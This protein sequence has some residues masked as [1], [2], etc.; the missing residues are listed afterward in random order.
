MEAPKF[1]GI[2]GDVVAY[3]VAFKSQKEGDR[4]EDALAATRAFLQSIIN[5]CGE[6]GVIYLTG[7]K[8]YRF[9][10]AGLAYPYKGNRK[11]QEKPVFL[12]DIRN[13]MID[14]F[15]AEVQEEQ[16]A[17][18]ALAIGAVQRR[19]GIATVD[20]DLDGVAGWHYNWRKQTKY[21]VTEVEADRFF[22]TQMLTGDAVDNIPGLSKRT[23]KKAMPKIK[24]PLQEM[25]DPSEMYTYVYQVYMDAVEEKAMSSDASD[26]TRW[27]LQQGR[28]L[29]MRREEDQIWVAP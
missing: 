9:A 1:W 22:Y 13:Y 3:A 8:N 11:D 7:S 28:C 26:V 27:L 6:E 5:E 16:E 18:D 15:A 20:K 17:D 21:Y 24:A 14:E 23:G 10:E 29:W 19:H 25:T 2:D 4:L 12:N